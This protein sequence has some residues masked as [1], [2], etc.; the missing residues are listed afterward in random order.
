MVVAIRFIQRAWATLPQEVLDG[1]L[2]KDGAPTERAMRNGFFDDI[3]LALGVSRK[4]F[5]VRGFEVDAS[6]EGLISRAI[7]ARADD[8]VRA[9]QVLELLHQAT[10]K[11]TEPQLTKCKKAVW[12][13]RKAGLAFDAELIS[14]EILEAGCST[15]IKTEGNEPLSVDNLKLLFRDSDS[16]AAA[17]SRLRALWGESPAT[18][19]P[20]GTQAA[21]YEAALLELA[22]LIRLGGTSRVN[23]E[24]PA[25]ATLAW[26]TALQLDRA[27]D[28][29]E[30]TGLRAPSKRDSS[31]PPVRT[32][33]VRSE[34]DNPFLQRSVYA[35]L[36]SVARGA[37]STSVDLVD[38]RS[39]LDIEI[40]A[41][42]S[43]LGLASAQARAGVVLMTV[44]SARHNVEI[45]GRT[46]T[47][48]KG[49]SQDGVPSF[50][51]NIITSAL[52][53]RL[54]QHRG[55]IARGRF[56]DL[57]LNPTPYL[58]SRTWRAMH[59]SDFRYGNPAAHPSGSRD[60][61]PLYLTDL[62]NFSRIVALAP[63]SLRSEV[64]KL[65]SQDTASNGRVGLPAPEDATPENPPAERAKTPAD[66]VQE[67]KAIEAVLRLLRE[68]IGDSRTTTLV[69]IV[70]SDELPDP[71]EMSD[72]RAQWADACELLPPQI[73]A[74]DFDAFQD[75][76]RRN[77]GRYRD[78]NSA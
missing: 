11:L 68:E 66:Q 51:A 18:P 75:Y 54:R 19:N 4:S 27:Q 34:D 25:R 46:F 31:P 6:E 12:A 35:R 38:T 57:I 14:A 77:L 59:N 52:A 26:E 39:A 49:G 33:G 65:I 69:E 60:P 45:N 8:F 43:P 48:D 29:E 64:G 67:W 62:G 42:A 13:A 3:S 40:V 50:I 16:I 53:Q 30:K 61:R 32:P 37:T 70:G 15:R 20:E 74:P 76:L 71:E 36:W 44:A 22:T 55:P 23:L 63:F 72:A 1:R 58:V 47:V 41:C 9:T 56:T 17:E 73:Q 2:T 7:Q 10:G 21:S 78:G 24:D 5:I 28:Y